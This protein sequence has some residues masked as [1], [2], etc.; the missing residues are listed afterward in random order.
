[1]MFC[2]LRIFTLFSF[3]CLNFCSLH[4]YRWYFGY[5][6]LNVKYVDTLK[7]GNLLR[8]KK[9]IIKKKSLKDQAQFTDEH[10]EC[11]INT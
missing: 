6:W 11:V 4:I 7:L 9:R 8:A 3:V 1:M 5:H 10:N 2:Y